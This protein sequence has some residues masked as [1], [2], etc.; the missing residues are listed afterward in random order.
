[1]SY[2]EIGR[3][4]LSPLQFVD[5]RFQHRRVALGNERAVGAAGLRPREPGDARELTANCAARGLEKR[6]RDFARGDLA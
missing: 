2:S 1:M 6:A 5:A 4:I 3:P